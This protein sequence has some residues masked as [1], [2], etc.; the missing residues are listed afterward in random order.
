VVERVRDPQQVARH[1]FLPFI[2][3]TLSTPQYK[4]DVGAIEV[5]KREIAY[6]AHMDAAIYSYYDDILVEAYERRITQLGLQDVPIAY[7]R[8]DERL[9]NINFAHRAFCFIASH[10]PCVAM[11]FDVKG[12]FD[13]INHDLLLG[14]WRD[15]LGVER[16]PADHFAIFKSVT[17]WESVDRDAAYEALGIPL[18]TRRARNRSLCSLRDFK[19]K[20][21][22]NGLIKRNPNPFG[23]PQ[24]SPMSA[25]LSNMYMLPFDLQISLSVA[26]CG[27]F[28]Q[29]YCDDVFLVVPLEFEDEARDLVKAAA[30][31]RNL[32][33][34]EEGKK[35]EI[36]QFP[37]PRVS[38]RSAKPI[39]YLGLTYD[40]AETLIRSQTLSRYHRKLRFYLRRSAIKAAH[41]V[42]HPWIYKRRLKA[43]FT[44]RGRRNFI[45][46]AEEC[47]RVTASMGI[48]GQVSR[49]TDHV[50]DWTEE[51]QARHIK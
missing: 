40:G 51:L 33:I 34:H 43:R 2:R 28:V 24:G 10:R 20:I 39:Q 38:Q 25:V 42:E 14:S 4:K 13:N 47:T 36:V 5:K 17:R 22:G 1:P 23:I 26:S 18:D 6:A 27:G 29:R 48:R 49:H 7:R 11:G 30:T 3:R 12:F 45:K 32:D 46:Y 50:H 15:V 16:L 35:I 8:F 21:R 31:E 19:C 9:C 44:H 37:D 41:N